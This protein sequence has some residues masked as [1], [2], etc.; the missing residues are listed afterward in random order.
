MKASGVARPRFQE[1]PRT[2]WEFSN[3]QLVVCPSCQ[4]RAEITRDAGTGAFSFR[5]TTCYY[6]PNQQPIYSLSVNQYCPACDHRVEHT[7][8][9]VRQKVAFIRLRCP[10]C[11]H[12]SRFT[13]RYEQQFSHLEYYGDASDSHFRYPLWLQGRIGKDVFWAYNHEHLNHLEAYIAA[14]LRGRQSLTYTTMVEKLPAFI[15]SA[16]NRE[17]LLTLI[18]KLRQQTT[19]AH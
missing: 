15:K 10:Y 12:T 1:G 17:A 7:I 2:L 6:V 19:L 9:Q 11:Q 4:Q 16:K 13:P 8:P 14:G 5:C 3:R 18:T